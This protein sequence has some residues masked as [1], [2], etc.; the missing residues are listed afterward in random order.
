M[1]DGLRGQFITIGRLKGVQLIIQRYRLLAHT[2]E[3]VL[4]I[5]RLSYQLDYSLALM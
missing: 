4:K 5:Y 2:N 3:S 1:T